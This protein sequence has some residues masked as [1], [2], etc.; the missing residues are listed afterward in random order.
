MALELQTRTYYS[1]NDLVDIV[2]EKSGKSIRDWAGKYKTPGPTHEDYATGNFPA[3]IWAKKYGYTDENTNLEDIYCAHNPTPEGLALRIKINTEY[4][5]APDGECLEEEI[6]YQDFWHYA[7]D[8]IFYE[9]SDGCIRYFNPYQVLE[10][11]KAN[12][13]EAWI[14]EVLEYFILVF[15][16][17]NLEESIEVEISW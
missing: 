11:A 17:N 15:K 1:W 10:N 5:D 7:I 9:V 3:G 4:R 6:P 13:E 14:I 2:E 16:E 8:N 12:N